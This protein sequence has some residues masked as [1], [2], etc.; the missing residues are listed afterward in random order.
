MTKTYRTHFG[1]SPT[2]YKKGGEMKLYDY[3]TD[4]ESG[5]VEADNLQD[6]L[7]TVAEEA[8]VNPKTIADGAWAWT[9]DSDGERLYLA[10]E[11]MP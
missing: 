11:N 1:M 3:R 8:G 9:E 5:V 7:D 10:E 6:A 2:A 4:G